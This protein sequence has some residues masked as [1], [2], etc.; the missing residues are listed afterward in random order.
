[1]NE[2][3]ERTTFNSSRGASNIDITAVSNQLLA[4]LS[5]WKISEEERFSDHPIIQY[6]VGHR[7]YCRNELNFYGTTYIVKEENYINFDEHLAHMAASR[8]G[9]AWAGD[10][11]ALDTALSS[12]VTENTDVED[13]TNKLY[14][15]LEEACSKKRLASKKTSKTRNVPWWSE[16]LTIL[17]KRLNALRS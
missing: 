14:D 5:G 1:M 7:D 3:S 4:E 12:R 9:V 2:E 6:S 11:D 8:F 10:K 16:E 15:V 17:R 13:S